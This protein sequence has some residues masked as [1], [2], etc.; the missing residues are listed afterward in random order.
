M[1]QS[2]IPFPTTGPNA[3]RRVVTTTDE[4]FAASSQ[5]LI[6]QY[7]VGTAATQIDITKVLGRRRVLIWNASST[8]AYLGVFAN[9]MS[10]ATLTSS[11][12]FPI[13]GGFT[14]PPQEFFVAETVDLWAATASGSADL[15]VWQESWA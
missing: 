14:T 10:G 7:T 13:P 5:I 11:V 9:G 12:G 15:R 8:H 1:S 4:Q 2:I 3:V 6:S